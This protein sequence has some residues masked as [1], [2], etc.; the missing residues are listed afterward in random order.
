MNVANT[1]VPPKQGKNVSKWLKIALENNRPGEEFLV[2]SSAP[3]G[4]SVLTCDTC[5]FAVCSFPMRAMR[6]QNSKQAIV[7]SSPLKKW[8]GSMFE[9]GHHS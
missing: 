2:N 6:I 7:K 3:G 5:S 9:T 4:K 8:I 1:M